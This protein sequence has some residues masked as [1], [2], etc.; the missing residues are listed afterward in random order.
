VCASP[1]E[2]VNLANAG[3]T[4][5]FFGYFKTFLTVAS[6]RKKTTSMFKHRISGVL[7]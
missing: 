5:L 2:F 4:G 1:Q 3:A 6:R 7:N